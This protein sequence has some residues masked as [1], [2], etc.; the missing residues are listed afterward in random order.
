MPGTTATTIAAI[1]EL[2]DDGDGATVY[3]PGEIL[4]RDFLAPLGLS[5]NALAMALRV[6]PPRVTELVRGRRGITADTALRLA[7]YLGTS[8]EFWMAL[9][10]SYDLAVVWGEQGARIEDDVTPRPLTEKSDRKQV[11]K[12]MKKRAGAFKDA[13]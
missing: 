13:L 6:P 2:D 11:A 12:V 7:R 3:H 5:S 9:Q 4:R 8:A 10:A 1:P